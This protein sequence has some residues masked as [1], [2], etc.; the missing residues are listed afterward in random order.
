MAETRENV[1]DRY[2]VKKEMYNAMEKV[3]VKHDLTSIEFVGI[4]EEIKTGIVIDTTIQ[5]WQKEQTM[6]LSPHKRLEIQACK[7]RF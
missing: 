2:E 1:I 3:A 5:E 4:L 6:Q 7:I